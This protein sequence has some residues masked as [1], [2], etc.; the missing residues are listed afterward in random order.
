MRRSRPGLVVALRLFGQATAGKSLRLV[1][2]KNRFA[3]RF[4]GTFDQR[5][6]RALLR[7]IGGGLFALNFLLLIRII[8]IA[9]PFHVTKDCF[10]HPPSADNLPSDAEIVPQTR[11][12]SPKQ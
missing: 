2:S 6:A 11:F 10:R 1:H 7:Q 4:T 3:E 5:L 12:F 9:D 8:G